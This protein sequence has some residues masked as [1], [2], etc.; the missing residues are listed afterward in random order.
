[1][2]TSAY[3][4]ERSCSAAVGATVASRSAAAAAGAATT[5]ASNRSS[6]TI[7]PPSVGRD[8]RHRTVRADR[9]T[10]TPDLG[11]G[12]GRQRGHPGRRRG[13]DRTR[14][15]GC[16]GPGLAPAEQQAAMAFRQAGELRHRCQTGP[17][18]VGRV[19]AAD[20]RID[21][22]FVD[23]VA[24][25]LPHEATER[26]VG[27]TTR[28]Q[29]LDRGASLATPAEQRGRHERPDRG[30]HAEHDAARDRMQ[31]VVP[32][33]GRCVGRRQSDP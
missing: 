18:G 22:P 11:G 27:V 6:S 25:T 31:S 28:E 26:V 14:R 19:D 16:G 30:G 21:E 2:I 12:S 32:H 29:R 4:I 23:L 7:Q 5:T 17:V 9:A 24:E 3:S 33:G 1:M 20:Q 15:G 13:E 10:A 8:E